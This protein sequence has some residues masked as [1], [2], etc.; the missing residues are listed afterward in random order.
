M[1]EHPGWLI[2]KRDGE[3]YPA[4]NMALPEVRAYWVSVISKALE[5]D[6]AG[7]HLDYIRYPVNQ[8]YSYDSI[9]C[10]NFSKSMD[11][12]L[13]K[14]QMMAEVLSGVNGLN[15]IRNRYLPSSEIYIK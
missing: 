10:D 14:L 5:Y 6:I 7:I 9:T 12:P 1:E 13:S 4:Y 3:V 2:R 8:M 11:S 15:G